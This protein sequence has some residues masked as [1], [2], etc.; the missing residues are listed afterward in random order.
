MRRMILIGLALTLSLHAIPFVGSA[1]A[2]SP[3]A[4]L[5]AWR[6]RQDHSP[7][8]QCW[9]KLERTVETP[10]RVA[11][12]QRWALSL[13]GAEL[14]KIE[15]TGPDL[16][17]MVEQLVDREY[18]EAF[19][20][21]SVSRSYYGPTNDYPEGRPTGFVSREPSGWDYAA[22]MPLVVHYRPFNRHFSP[23]DDVV[24]TLEPKRESINGRE[25]QHLQPENPTRV[26]YHYW[27]DP[28]RDWVVVR[29]EKHYTARLASRFD[30]EY[31][32]GP[33]GSQ[34]LQ[35]WTHSSFRD[36]QTTET[37]QATVLETDANAALSD[38]DFVFEFPPNT[39]VTDRFEDR[40]VVYVVRPNNVKRIV[41]PEERRYRMQYER[42][43]ETESGEAVD[44]SE[45]PSLL[46]T[47]RRVGREPAAGQQ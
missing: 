17:P 7:A 23:I 32:Q 9:Y 12:T 6:W 43:L 39:L 13:K 36:G 14:I 10:R 26:A 18:V 28:R 40:P 44:L 47:N 29:I 42:Y 5:D 4:V 33:D 2:E 22:L 11:M 1:R 45:P 41:T 34:K 25:C 31:A 35:S 24:Y 19:D 46:N 21:N 16:Y 37:S 38:S 27:V 20:A 8:I 15:R 30:V 3:A